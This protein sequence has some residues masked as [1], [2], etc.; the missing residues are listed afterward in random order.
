[1]GSFQLFHAVVSGI[2][3]LVGCEE[4]VLV[5]LEVILV[6]DLEV[7]IVVELELVIVVGLEVV[8]TFD[9]VVAFPSFEY[10]SAPSGPWPRAVH[11]I[12]L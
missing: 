1:M 11:T 12:E 9:V 5:E 7:V 4:V 6:V 2:A 10:S 8:V 3:M